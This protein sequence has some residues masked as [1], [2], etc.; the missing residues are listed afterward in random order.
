MS[1]IELT[2]P[3][4]HRWSDSPP[5]FRCSAGIPSGPQA[6][7]D[8]SFF[9][10]HNTSSKVK[11]TSRMYS[12]FERD[13][14]A[15]LSI[16]LSSCWRPSSKGSKDLE[17]LLKWFAQA[18]TKWSLADRISPFTQSLEHLVFSLWGALKR[19]LSF[20]L[21]S[22]SLLVMRFLSSTYFRRWLRSPLLS[23]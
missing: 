20:C 7:P 16:F 4:S 10:A 9:T 8:F 22:L 15:R 11:G 21:N 12:S 23:R 5:H 3:R 2:T 17:R 1:T 19:L 18:P 6:L 13:A 14:V